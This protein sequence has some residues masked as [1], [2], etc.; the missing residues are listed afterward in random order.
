MKKLKTWQLILL[1]VFYPIGI[2]YFIVWLINKNKKPVTTVPPQQLNILREFHSKVVGVTFANDNG[3]S[4]QDIIRR[5]KTGDDLVFK[6]TPTDKHPES[7]GVFNNRG[8]QLGNVSADT[9]H[10][11]ITKYPT[12]PMKVIITDITGGGDKNYGC[13][14]LITIYR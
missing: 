10:E 2:I 11:L 5:C 3:T 14:F 7:I 13:N 4:R 8:E 12:N 6:P 1:I 9:A